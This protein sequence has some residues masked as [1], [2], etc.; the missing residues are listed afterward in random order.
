MELTSTGITEKAKSVYNSFFKTVPCINT[1]DIWSDLEGI[2]N[3][4]R[5]EKSKREK[6]LL[7]YNV[8]GEI[9][10]ITNIDFLEKKLNFSWW[11]TMNTTGFY[12]SYHCDLFT[13]ITER[14]RILNIINSSDKLGMPLINSN[15]V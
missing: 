11:M 7:T 10:K 14:L 1:S 3:K 13:K 2:D 9:N 8:E 15:R 6:E 5:I 12:N 4:F